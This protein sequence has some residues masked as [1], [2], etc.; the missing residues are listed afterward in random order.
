[1]ISNE[2]FLCHSYVPH[3]SYH[4]TN[5]VASVIRLFLSSSISRC[6]TASDISAL[7]RDA[8][9]MGSRTLRSC[10][11]YFP[12]YIVP[13]EGSQLRRYVQLLVL[14]YSVRHWTRCQ[15]SLGW[16]QWYQQNYFVALKFNQVSLEN[17]IR[18][19]FSFPNVSFEGAAST[20]CLHAVSC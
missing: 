20:Y 6:S 5:P 15:Q 3:Q 13:Y 8:I 4:V 19:Y 17:I 7:R 10:W 11:A 18:V 1:M 14:C 9:F 2:L 12:Q 16:Q